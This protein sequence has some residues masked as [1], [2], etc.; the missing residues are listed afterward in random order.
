MQGKKREIEAIEKTKLYLHFRI[1]MDIYAGCSTISE[2]CKQEAN[3]VHPDESLQT[4]LPLQLNSNVV[5]IVWWPISCK[6]NN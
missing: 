3:P 1:V 5:R 2:S 4:G 6:L